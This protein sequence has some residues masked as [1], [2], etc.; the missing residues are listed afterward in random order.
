[1]HQKMAREIR[2]WSSLRHP[3]ILP[4]LGFVM[5]YE[6]YPALVTEWMENGTAMDYL[7]KHPD[8]DILP[9]ARPQ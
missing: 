5:D 4:L 8:L 7:R 9:M 2:I 3:N 1:M 6:V